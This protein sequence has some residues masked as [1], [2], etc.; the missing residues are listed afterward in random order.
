MNIGDLVLIRECHSI[1]AL[2]GQEAKVV[3]LA[4]PELAKY[5]VQVLLTGDPIKMVTP[6]GSVLSKGPFH[7]REDEL[8]PLDPNHGIPEVFLKG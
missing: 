4:D 6:S 1:P 2:V 3:V 5:P 8:E 7:F